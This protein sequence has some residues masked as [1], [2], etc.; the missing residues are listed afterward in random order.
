MVHSMIRRGGAVAV[1]MALMGLAG[2]AA[3]TAVPRQSGTLSGTVTDPDG[4][5]LPGVAVTLAFTG[6]AVTT[7]YTQANG[8]FSFP[9][10]PVETDLAVSFQLEG[11]KPVDAPDVRI[12][13]ASSAQV[14]VRLELATQPEQIEITGRPRVWRSERNPM[15]P[16]LVVAPE[17]EEEPEEGLVATWWPV[18]L[19][20]LLAAATAL[21][22]LR[23]L[24]LA[25]Q[26]RA[27]P[28][29]TPDFMARRD[30]PIPERS[31]DR[32]HLVVTV[33]GIR[34][35]GHW[36]EALGNLLYAQDPEVRC[37]HYTYGYFSLFAFLVPPTR[38]L[39]TRRFRRHLLALATGDDWDRIDIVAH[40]FGTHLVCWGIDGIPERQRPRVNTL[41]LAASV[42]KPSFPWHRLVGRGV[43]RVVN[44]CGTKDNVLIL[45]QAF[46]LLTG[47]AGRV[48]FRGMTGEAFR[49]RFFPF[50]HSEYF[51]RGNSPDDG[52]MKRFWL[53]IL[54]SGTALEP[55]DTRETPGLFARLFLIVLNNAEPLKIA[56]AFVA[57][58]AFTVWIGGLYQNADEQRRRA[59]ASSVLAWATTTTDPLTAALLMM[60]MP[61]VADAPGAVALARDISTQRLPFSVLRHSDEVVDVAMSPDGSQLVTGS[62]D[63]LTVLWD[64]TGERLPLTLSRANGVVRRVAFSRDGTRV[65]SAAA[66]GEVTVWDVDDVPRPI[67]QLTGLRNSESVAFT[68]DGGSVVIAANRGI[69]VW[70]PGSSTPSESICASRYAPVYDVAVSP[71]GQTVAGASANAVIVCSMD[72]EVEVVP[73]IQGESEPVSVAFDA[74]GEY[75]AAGFHD[76]SLRVWRQV[77]GWQLIMEEDAHSDSVWRVAFGGTDRV[78]SASADGTVQVRHLARGQLE[79]L[80]G[81]SADDRFYGAQFDSDGSVLVASASDGGIRLWDMDR[82][83]ATDSQ[84]QSGSEEP[85]RQV[86]A[87]F[88]ASAVVT[89]CESGRPC[90]RGTRVPEQPVY[91]L[92]VDDA[93]AACWAADGESVLTLTDGGELALWV[94]QQVAATGTLAVQDPDFA[95]FSPD[96]TVVAVVSWNRVDRW[97]TTAPYR[98]V[99]EPI[100]HDDEVMAVAFSGD[101]ARFATADVRVV[102]LWDGEGN[103]VGS[104]FT[105]EDGA[106]YSVALDGDGD[107]LAVGTLIPVQQTDSDE[108]RDLLYAGAL[109]TWDLASDPP[110]RT[111]IAGGVG[112]APVMAVAFSADDSLL[113]AGFGDG[114]VRL[115]RDDAQGSPVEFGRAGRDIFRDTMTAVG[116]SGSG[117]VLTAAHRSGY[118]FLWTIGLDEMRR[119][120]RRSTTA[121]LTPAERVRFLTELA[122]DAEAGWS[123]CVERYGR[124]GHRSE[125][126]AGDAVAPQ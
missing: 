62:N 75:L 53:P 54:T 40:S 48:G 33:H 7:T 52:F 36:Q 25:R 46:V 103:Q 65:A 69:R 100:E 111:T 14:D 26:S 4:D 122:A 79:T 67:D 85:V 121:C 22:G 80:R 93:L 59:Q 106:I 44:E 11:F 119:A 16:G 5:P 9:D 24:R 88:D 118:L 114:T 61:A 125:A 113:A 98:S 38:W 29:G 83:L 102:N 1:V 117:G 31:G 66:S 41:I 81:S 86:C 23:A 2:L 73:L 55:V 45:S 43:R 39:V 77:D 84:F 6:T 8:R 3:A 105:S 112:V 20:A 17:N 15:E 49:N 90:V 63:R 35:F 58:G 64:V 97:E 27:D 95:I 108:V 32:R 47:M 74:T 110:S 68:P 13:E 18:A 109:R 37:E 99:G 10:V 50:G 12:R 78:A 34:T 107:R 76:G 56:A 51:G 115:F 124:M 72:R 94:E 30:M 70:T 123:S 57:L 89:V 28:Q 19:G 96:R 87:N 60:E 91:E 21:A 126:A 42:L 71:D 101:G 82:G 92:G 120:F 104:P 116:F